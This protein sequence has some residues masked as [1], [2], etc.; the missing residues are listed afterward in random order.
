MKRLA[1]IIIRIRDRIRD[2]PV[3]SL[4]YYILILAGVAAVFLFYSNNKVSYIYN[5]F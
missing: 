5:Q 1:A 2:N 3:L 4:L